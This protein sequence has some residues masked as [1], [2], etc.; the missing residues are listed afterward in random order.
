MIIKFYTLTG[1]TF[2]IENVCENILINEIYEILSQKFSFNK[3]GIQLFYQNIVI[4][5]YNGE[6]MLKHY[7]KDLV[8]ESLIKILVI[9]KLGITKQTEQINNVC[10]ICF[11]R[12][13]VNYVILKQ[14]NHMVCYDCCYNIIDKK[15]Y[16]CCICNKDIEKFYH[17]DV[18]AN[19]RK[20]FTHF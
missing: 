16:K 5:L 18:A 4:D 14:C 7:I 20:I 17:P 15:K 3:L 10:P 1:E 12:N 9:S 19:N 11:K 13:P 2:I 6:K 8:A